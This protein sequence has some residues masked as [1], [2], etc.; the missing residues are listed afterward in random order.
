VGISA[1]NQQGQRRVHFGQTPTIRVLDRHSKIIGASL[2]VTVAYET[3]K[4]Q[5]AWIAYRPQYGRSRQVGDRS[6]V[7]A[8]GL[9]ASSDRS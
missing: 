4:T 1:L 8:E 6:A 2:V 5:L 7:I 3:K 9:L